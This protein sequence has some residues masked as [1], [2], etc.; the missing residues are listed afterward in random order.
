[1]DLDVYLNRKLKG[2]GF[3]FHARFFSI[4]FFSFC[5]RRRDESATKHTAQAT[6]PTAPQD[7][8]RKELVKWIS[9]SVSRPT[10]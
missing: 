3:H 5:Q 8:T 10:A 6:Q 9:K 7:K 2:G 4:K 1:M